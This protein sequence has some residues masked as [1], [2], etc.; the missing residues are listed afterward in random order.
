MRLLL[1]ECVPGRL[2][3]SLPAHRVSTVYQAG[4][5][6]IKNGQLLALAAE[7]FDAFITVDKNLP[8]QQDLARYPITVI[9]L[10]T[11]S[12]ELHYL[13]PLLP[14]LEQVLASALPGSMY[15]VP[16]AN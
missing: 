4:W 9:V 14:E 8:H 15:R 10:H 2:A 13:L 12:N 7:H 3:R 11:V 6:G 1:D 16:H 5:S